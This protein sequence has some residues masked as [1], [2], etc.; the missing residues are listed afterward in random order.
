MEIRKS[1]LIT[2]IPVIAYY[3][4][5]EKKL[6]FASVKFDAGAKRGQQSYK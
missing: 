2:E 4:P 1:G 5:R 6:Y 3:G